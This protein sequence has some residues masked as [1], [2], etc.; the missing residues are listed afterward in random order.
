M[1]GKL[2]G[3]IISREPNLVILDVG[4]VGYRV[5]V[6]LSTYFQLSEDG[7]AISLEICT[8]VK[9][10]EISLY[11]FISNQEKAL[12]EQLISISGIG[13]KLS[14]NIM[15]GI[16]LKELIRAIALAD[17]DRLRSI[18]G[19]GKKMAE[20]IILE[21]K[22]RVAEHSEEEIREM[23]KLRKMDP[24]E[25][26][27]F[28]DTK[29]ALVNLGFAAALSGKAVEGAL[30][31]WQDHSSERFPSFEDLFKAALKRLMKR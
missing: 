7:K 31:E 4:G 25:R 11:G 15:S 18:P 30:Q 13:P 23:K 29:S 21:L 12:F 2:R 27:L 1:I 19:V 17:G 28:D 16:D 14:I 8:C 22:D 5:H 6:P 9:E 26:K 24:S 20:R 3:H 10:N